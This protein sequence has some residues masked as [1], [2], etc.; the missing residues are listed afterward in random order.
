MFLKDLC[1]LPMVIKISDQNQSVCSIEKQNSSSN[2][3]ESFKKNLHKTFLEKT[4][5]L[6]VF[7]TPFYI[8]P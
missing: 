2:T 3:P 7:K 6:N 4:Y 8:L 1:L 5:R